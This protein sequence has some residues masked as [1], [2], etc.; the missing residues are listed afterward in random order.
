MQHTLTTEIRKTDEISIRVLEHINT[1]PSN[2]LLTTE[3]I[4]EL[5]KHFKILTELPSDDGINYFIYALPSP[6]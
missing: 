4:I 2:S 3:H 5:L 6:T 1:Q